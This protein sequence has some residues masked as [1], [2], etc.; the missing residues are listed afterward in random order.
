MN[1]VMTG[2]T[3]FLGRPLSQRL[4]A[5]GHH[6]TVLSRTP[7]E[8]ALILDPAV[9]VEGWDAETRGTWERVLDNADAVINLTGAPIAD[10]RWTTERKRV[11]LHSRIGP[12]RLLVQ[13]LT[14]AA[15]RPRT[16]VSA[17]GIGFYGPRDQTPVDEATPAGNGFLADLTVA[18]ER[19]ACMAEQSGVRVV[20]LRM[21]MVL[22]RD[23]GA[24]PRM[25]APFR[26]FVGGP[27]CPGEQWISWIHRHDVIGLVSWVLAHPAM[28]GSVNAVA[29][30][31]VTMRTFCRTLGRVLRRPSW[32]PVPQ[33]ALHLA[34]G[35]L[36]TV[37]TTGQHV[38][39][40][41][42]IRSGYQFQFPHLELALQDIVYRS[43]TTQQAA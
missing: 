26:I 2:G 22:E 19:E 27:V 39:A 20:L 4:S 7:R 33:L 18:W 8:A 9:R 35:E 38:K 40:T 41:A 25:L 23:G 21:G 42:A 6:V 16:L 11:L 15:R 28:A 10:A 3:G 29:P 37:L 34:L 36:G 14:Q 24:L 32:L 5:D 43:D 17:S 30:E 1:I 31:A 12:T 13:A